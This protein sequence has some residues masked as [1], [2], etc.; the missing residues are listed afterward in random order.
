M[1][2]QFWQSHGY[3]GSS[4]FDFSNN[5]L[6]IISSK[7]LLYNN[8][9]WRLFSWCS[10]YS[11]LDCKIILKK[12]KQLRCI[13]WL[14]SLIQTNAS[15]TEHIPLTFH[16]LQV[17]I[18]VWPIFPTICMQSLKNFSPTRKKIL[19]T[20]M[21]DPFLMSFQ[22]E[23]GLRIKCKTWKARRLH[24]IL[25]WNKRRDALTAQPAFKHYYTSAI[26][27]VFS[28]AAQLQSRGWLPPS[29]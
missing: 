26:Q 27:P 14:W 6:H 21:L 24:T 15:F 18:T 11:F 28:P 10:Y 13:V 1:Q 5:Y 20:Y 8:K 19:P 23:M 25:L 16:M 4:N 3:Y 12:R 17:Y 9:V 2:I 22:G 7:I 29:P